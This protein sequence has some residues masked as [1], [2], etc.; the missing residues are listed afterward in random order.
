MKRE[1]RAELENI[2]HNINLN[3]KLRDTAIWYNL[4]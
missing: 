1:Y 2:L 3:V 4:L